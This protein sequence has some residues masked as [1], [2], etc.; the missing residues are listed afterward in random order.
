MWQF[1]SENKGKKPYSHI[2]TDVAY[3]I[4]DKRDDDDFFLTPH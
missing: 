2:Q 3:A 1:K 4:S